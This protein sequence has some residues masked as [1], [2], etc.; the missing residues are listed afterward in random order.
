MTDL[1]LTLRERVGNYTGYMKGDEV[2]GEGTFVYIDGT[3]AFGYGC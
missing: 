3:Q 1:P 2:H